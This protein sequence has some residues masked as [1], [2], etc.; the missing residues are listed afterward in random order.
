MTFVPKRCLLVHNPPHFGT[1]GHKTPPPLWRLLVG[2]TLA[3]APQGVWFAWVTLDGPVFSRFENDI[4]TLGKLH[5]GHAVC[6]VV[7][8]AG[9]L[10]A[11]RPLQRLVGHRASVALG[12]M[13]VGLGLLSS[14]LA[15]NVW[16]FL[17]G[18][19][20]VVAIGCALALS[21]PLCLG[22]YHY[23]RRKGLLSGVV[24]AGSFLGAALAAALAFTWL[25][26]WLDFEG[27]DDDA[28]PDCSGD[29]VNKGSDNRCWRVPSALALLGLGV[30]ALGSLG[31]MLLPDSEPGSSGFVPGVG[32]HRTSSDLHRSR[33]SGLLP[34]PHN[35]LP[36]SSALGL[37]PGTGGRDGVDGTDSTRADVWDRRTDSHPAGAPGGSGGE[38]GRGRGGRNTSGE[39][40]SQALGSDA[41]ARTQDG[42]VRGDGDEER[43]S[44]FGSSPSLASEASGS[45]HHRGSSFGNGSGSLVPGSSP[46]SSHAPLSRN[47]V[48]RPRL[49]VL[50]EGAAKLAAAEKPR[51]SLIAWLVCARASHTPRDASPT[52]NRQQ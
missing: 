38:R 10:A 29:L 2:G 14:A 27:G 52:A 48:P 15:V 23:P 25:R 3:R 26:P 44:S 42:S 12:A 47:G 24:N 16:Q 7:G 8:L 31:A 5:A 49:S 30:G 37:G 36:G 39:L 13:F 32:T 4:G 46:G 18:S 43:W 51:R 11:V 17:I 40:S 33:H 21:P 35:P 34:G 22:F 19:G 41:D 6:L 9:C 50:S 28:V 45:M 20:A 1:M